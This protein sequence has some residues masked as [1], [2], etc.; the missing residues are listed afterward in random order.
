[1]K[2][3]VLVVHGGGPTSVMNSSLYGVIKAAENVPDIECVY[4]AIGGMEGILKE[5]LV[6]LKQLSSEQKE[7]LLST[8]GSVIGSSR[9][10]ITDEDYITMAKNLQKYNIKILLPNGGNGT[11]DA[12]GRL[13]QACEKLGNHDVRV[14]GIPKT[15]DNDIAITDHTPGYGSAAR[16]LAATVREIAEDIRSLPI[17]VCVIEA[18]GRNSGWIT[19]A[20]AL[21]RTNPGDAPHLIYTPECEFDEEKFLADVKRLYEKLGGVVVVAS[22]GLKN[23]KGEPIVEPIF[24]TQR[25]IYYGDVSAYLTE[26]IIKKL[27]IKARSEKPGLAGR[28]S[29]A[30]QSVCDRDEASLAGE[31]ALNKALQGKTGIM[32]GFER[33][34]KEKDGYEIRIVEIPIEEVMLYEKTL[35][36]HYLSPEGNDVTEDFINWCRPLLGG[37]FEEFCSLSEL[38]TKGKKV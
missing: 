11:M 9:F 34:P 7:R 19:A 10:P 33:V 22:E 35:P 17:H 25:A 2:K 38:K 30:W 6:D 28:A 3:N 24:R 36:D 5:N 31:Q 21:A 20:S 14:V 8:P 26:L 4:G 29:I 15:I 37:E 27:G 13:Y 12:C 16:Y 1:M 18:L 23:K 32:I